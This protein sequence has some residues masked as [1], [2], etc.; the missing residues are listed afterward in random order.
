MTGQGRGSQ[1]KYNLK[2]C[3]FNHFQLYFEYAYE[4]AISF[5]SPCKQH[6]VIENIAN[7]S[8]PPPAAQ[9]KCILPC[10]DKHVTLPVAFKRNP[11]NIFQ[12]S[13]DKNTFLYNT[14][15]I[16]PISTNTCQ[17]WAWQSQSTVTCITLPLTSKYNFLHLVLG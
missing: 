1:V 11:T 10:T 4:V 9:R 12:N 5:I 16:V 15:E 2:G 7:N 14:C 3:I 6:T 8:L 17:E 13:T